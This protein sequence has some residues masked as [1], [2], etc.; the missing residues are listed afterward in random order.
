LPSGEGTAPPTR[1]SFIMSSKVKGR[2]APE[3]AFVPGLG[4]DVWA[5]ADAAIAKNKVKVLQRISDL[6]LRAQAL[7]EPVDAQP[8]HSG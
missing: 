1:F 2:L 5:K 7:A 3:L 4:L 6:R 8:K